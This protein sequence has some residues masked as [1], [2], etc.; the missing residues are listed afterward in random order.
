MIHHD[1]SRKTAFAGRAGGTGARYGAASPD[2]EAVASER[3]AA[4]WQFSPS[5]RDGAEPATP[6]PPSPTPESP[7][8]P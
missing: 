3:G 8:N 4:F 1:M 7:L 2:T 6:L 5:P